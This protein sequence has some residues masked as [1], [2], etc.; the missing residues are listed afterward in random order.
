MARRLRGGRG[1][2]QDLS[3]RRW[4]RGLR[5]RFALAAVIGLLLAAVAAT[6]YATVPARF[7]IATKNWTPQDWETHLEDVISR[8][9]VAPGGAADIHQSLGRWYAPAEPRIALEHYRKAAAFPSHSAQFRVDL[10][11]AFLSLGHF[12]EAV[13]QCQKALELEPGGPMPTI[14]WRRLVAQGRAGDAIAQ[15][16]RAIALN[17]E[18]AEAHNNLG[19]PLWQP[20]TDRRGDRR[21]T[22]KGPGNQSPD[23]AEPITTSGCALAGCGRIEEAIAHYQKA[24]ELKPDYARL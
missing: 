5:P 1:A 13:E 2:G 6:V 16:R 19:V 14:A 8:P 9:G 21:I 23:Y 15:F 24:L 18:F 10:G 3:R 17:P 4:S 12:D 22:E 20:R 7:R 11:N